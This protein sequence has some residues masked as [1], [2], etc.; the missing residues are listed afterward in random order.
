MLR[1]RAAGAAEAATSERT[2]A[3]PSASP[4]IADPGIDDGVETVD[5]EVHHGHDGCGG[6]HHCL[7]HRKITRA[8]AFVSQPP[9]AG[10]G[11]DRLHHDG[12][13]DEDREVYAGK[14]DRREERR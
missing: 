13:G 9:E 8:D 12:G 11:E 3:S 7:D 2:S 4:G 5:A 10:P 14:G 6:E 1:L